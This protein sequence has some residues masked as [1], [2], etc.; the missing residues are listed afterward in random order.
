[1]RAGDWKL[2]EYLED[3]RIE[4]FNLRDDPGERTDLAAQMPEKAAE[5]SARLHAWRR[6]VGAAMP[7]PNPSF[8]SPAKS[9]GK[10]A[11]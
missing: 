6:S 5:L 4:L 10:K 2:L 11:G 3:R 8:P 7:K 9:A 1:V